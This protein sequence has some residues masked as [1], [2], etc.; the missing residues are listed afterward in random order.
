MWKFFYRIVI[1]LRLRDYFNKNSIFVNAFLDNKCS[2]IKEIINSKKQEL[3]NLNQYKQSI[4]YEY[5]TGKKQVPTEE[6]AKE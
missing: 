5:V 1:F 6:G 4:I 2:N 3:T